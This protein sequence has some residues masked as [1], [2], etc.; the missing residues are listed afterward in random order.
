MLLVIAGVLTP[1]EAKVLGAAA[2]A[3]IVLLFITLALNAVAIYFRYR[4]RRKLQW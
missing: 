4:L 2:A 3:G 1:V